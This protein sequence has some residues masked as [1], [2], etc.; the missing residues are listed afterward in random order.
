MSRLC[1]IRQSIV[2]P[3]HRSNS[4]VSES[5]DL[6]WTYTDKHPFLAKLLRP[7]SST[8]KLQ[9]Y[10][11]VSS[12]F[13]GTIINTN[14]LHGKG[15][16]SRTCIVYGAY[17]HP[18][19]TAGLALSFAAAAL[20]RSIWVS[21]EAYRLGIHRSIDP[22]MR[23]MSHG[24][25]CVHFSHGDK[26]LCQSSIA[27]TS[28]LQI[29]LHFHKRHRALS[30][31]P[32]A[33][34]LCMPTTTTP[35]ALAVLACPELVLAI[36]NFQAGVYDDYHPIRCVGRFT[37][38]STQRSLD[39]MRRIDALLT[40]WHAFH[41][42]PSLPRMSA[43]VRSMDRHR[44]NI[45]ASHAAF[46]GHLPVLRALLTGTAHRCTDAHLVDWA[47]C[48]GQLHVLQF[49]VESTA[50]ARCT[51]WAIDSAAAHGHLHVV[52]YLFAHGADP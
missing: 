20:A 8:S 52:Q 2:N 46:A 9:R 33:S 49:L 21:L 4:L 37:L 51:Q 32:P 14:F 16:L 40:P 24:L 15:S 38:T 36:V 17:A 6:L 35:I 10:L 19:T 12:R 43:L 1:V 41:T 11:A 50:H 7:A 27:T 47:A 5:N 13:Q 44:H 3:A 25:T 29:M 48:N 23:G 45:I 22:A 26:D 42:A 18:N 30:S 28:H 34:I 31:P 39:D